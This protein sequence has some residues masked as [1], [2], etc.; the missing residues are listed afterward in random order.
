MN[1]ATNARDAMP[2]GGTLVIAAEV[3]EV[4]SEF[5]TAH[6]YGENGEYALITVSDSGDG[7]DIETQKRIFEPFFTTKEVGKGTGLGLA[8]V[9]GII[10]QHNGYINVYSEPGMGSIFKI[11][12]PIIEA[13]EQTL[14]TERQEG[15]QGGNETILLAEDE[16][17]VREVNRSILEEFGY[18]VIE[19]VDG[20]DAVSKFIEN[21]EDIDILLID[22]IMPK[23]NGR[24][25]YEEIVRVKPD[26]KAIFLSGYAA[27]MMRSR[28][29]I[30][31]ATDFICKPVAPGELLKKVREALDK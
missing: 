9:Y 28:G 18:R 24:E 2:G 16:R 14:E 8:V 27:D 31:A 10:K 26:V 30:G 13:S 5:I 6:G 3:V 1:L 29:L 17:E 21:S 12:L 4:G 19:A 25:A 11:Y 7:M 22:L 20:T 15:F 23:K